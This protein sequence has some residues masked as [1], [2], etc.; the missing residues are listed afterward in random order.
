MEH[1]GQR[2]VRSDDSA[3]GFDREFRNYRNSDPSIPQGVIKPGDCPDAGFPACN[4]ATNSRITITGA[5][6]QTALNG[7]YLFNN[8]SSNTSNGITTTT[9][10]VSTGNAADGTYNFS[11]EPQLAVTYLGP[12]STSGHSDF[13]GGG[14]SVLT[15]G[16]WEADDLLT[17]RPTRPAT[18]IGPG[19][20]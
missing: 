6:A 5:L 15:L 20:L 17:A 3:T 10:T 11:N 19:I 12:T 2:T 13:G 7:T 9:F 8:V 18:G 1:G 14:D 16:L 4:D